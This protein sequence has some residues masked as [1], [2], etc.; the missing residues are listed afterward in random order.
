MVKV[1]L[2]LLV[3]PWRA[4][5]GW[6]ASLPA[7]ASDRAA[8]PDAFGGDGY[9]WERQPHL[10]PTSLR[11]ILALA[12]LFNTAA[13]VRNLDPRWQ[14]LA[15]GHGLYG[16][17]ESGANGQVLQGFDPEVHRG[18]FLAV[19]GPS[20]CGKSTFLNILTGLAQKSADELSNDG[21]PCGDVTIV[22]PASRIHIF[23]IA[24]ALI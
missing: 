8:A 3:G 22:G 5:E 17:S 21:R 19:L 2:T 14:Q 1:L 12:D 16:C 15:P 10:F 4:L 11:R 13:G 23:D 24:V 6:H 18:N 7:P 9:G 20:G